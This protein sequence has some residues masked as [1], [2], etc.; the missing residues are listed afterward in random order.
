L[1]LPARAA[2]VV[3]VHDLDFLTHPE[4]AQ[5]E[6]RRDYPRLAADHAQRARAVI[7]PSEYTRG[8]VQQQLRVPGERIVVCS[9]GIPEWRASAAGFRRDGYVLFMGS[10]ERRKN[11]AGLLTAYSRIAEGWSRVPRLVLA[12]R[13]GSDIA[14]VLDRTR[15]SPLAGHV[16]QLGYVAD[17]KRQDVLEGARVLVLPSLEEGFGM[18]ALEAMSLGIPVVVSARGALPEVVGDAGLVFEPTDE[19]ALFDALS[20]VLTDDDLA[21]RLGSRGRER[22]RSFSWHRTAM[23]VR[24][25]FAAALERRADQ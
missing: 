11:I 1:L 12:G 21:Q 2:Q 13:P 5:R 15:Q 4:R 6:I 19:A 24:T 25:A 22:A 8:E 18:P 16:D 23:K 17:S 20:R 7:V 3:M 9:P 10:L 14:E